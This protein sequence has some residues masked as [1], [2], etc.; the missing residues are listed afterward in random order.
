MRIVKIFVGVLFIV[1]VCSF[2]YA[3]NPDEINYD[4]VIDDEKQEL[5]IHFTPVAAFHLIQELR[6]ELRMDRTIK[7]E[8]YLIDF[9]TYF[10]ETISLTIGGTPIVLKLIKSDLM[11]HDAF[12]TFKVENANLEEVNYK[13][14]ITSFTEIF[15]RIKNDVLITADNKPY[16]SSLNKSNTEN[17]FKVVKIEEASFNSFLMAGVAFMVLVFFAFILKLKNQRT[18]AKL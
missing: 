1:F 14:S 11:G 13:I 2:S 9:E 17:S 6:V 18:K 8:N 7:L 15:P 10:N 3:H 16:Y 12:M 5:N 4:F